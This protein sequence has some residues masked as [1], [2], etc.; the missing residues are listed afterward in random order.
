M[1][2]QKDIVEAYKCLLKEI[3]LS[4]ESSTYIELYSME[5]CPHF[6]KVPGF[7]DSSMQECPIQHD[8]VP[9]RIPAQ[10]AIWS[11]DGSAP[12]VAAGR[13]RVLSRLIVLLVLALRSSLYDSWHR[14][15]AMP[16]A[17]PSGSARMF[18]CVRLLISLMVA[19]QPQLRKVSSWRWGSVY[20]QAPE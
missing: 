10:D 1:L 16:R 2:P 6:R 11:F 8:S 13:E 19:R 14:P 20:R 4:Q 5:F 15:T 17:L 12:M 3:T 18:T 9:K 7:V